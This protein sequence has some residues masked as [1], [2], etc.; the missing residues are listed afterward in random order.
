MNNLIVL[1]Q[2]EKNSNPISFD[3]WK[4]YCAKHNLQFIYLTDIINPN[5]TREDQIFYIFDVLKANNIEFDQICL[6]S[7]NTLI[8]SNTVNVFELT[9]N[10]LTFAEWDSDF[11]YLINQIDYYKK[12][13]F[14]NKQVDYSRF[15]DFGFFI[16]NK[17]HE[18]IFKNICQFLNN[19]HDYIALN[20]FFECEY[21]KLPYSYNMIDLSRKEALDN[22]IFIKVGN[23]YNFNGLDNK[24]SLM[25]DVSNML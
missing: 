1:Y 9:N 25:Y 3:N 7:D 2:S 14:N 4:K 16:I 10:K 11:G 22:L 13:V 8:N 21:T 23:I 12:N 17:T 15:F 24:L 19:K 18:N 5:F 20:F 6:A